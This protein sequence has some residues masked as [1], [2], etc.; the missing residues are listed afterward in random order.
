MTPEEFKQWFARLGLKEGELARR[1]DVKQ[2]TINRWFTGQRTPPGY[3]WRALEH[4]E[5]EL[6]QERA[7]KPKRPK[8]RAEQRPSDAGAGEG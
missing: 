5:V 1:L 6:R 4:L 7:P 8:R 2:P 3:L